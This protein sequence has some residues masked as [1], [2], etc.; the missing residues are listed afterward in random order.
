MGFGRAPLGLAIELAG[1]TPGTGFD[2]L[3]VGG[4]ASLGGILGVTTI[5]SFVPTTADIFRFLTVV[6][7]RT[8]TFASTTLPS[9]YAGSVTYGSNFADLGFS[10]VPAAPVPVAPVADPGFPAL[11]QT[12]I[13]NLPRPD[14]AIPA[15]VTNP[16]PSKSKAAL[17]VESDESCQ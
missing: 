3:A 4:N 5:G 14:P 1:A 2:R 13:A 7:I 15:D 16:Q 11:T 10:A 8:G 9:G 17:V 6:G 12:L